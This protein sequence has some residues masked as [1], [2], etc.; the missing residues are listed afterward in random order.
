ML[1]G[2][3]QK[4]IEMFQKAIDSSPSYFER[5]QKNLKIALASKMN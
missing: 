2:H 5:A 1:E 4:A 3:Y